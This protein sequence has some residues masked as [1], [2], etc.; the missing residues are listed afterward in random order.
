MRITRSR[1]GERRVWCAVQEMSS[2]R[3]RWPEWAGNVLYCT[4]LYC[5]VLY[6]CVSDTI[7][8]NKPEY[9]GIENRNMTVNTV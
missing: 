3:D 5:T 9:Y 2:T 4:I 6:C 8:H 1:G 7:R